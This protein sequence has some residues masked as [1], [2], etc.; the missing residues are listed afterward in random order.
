[1][2]AKLLLLPFPSPPAAPRHPPPPKSLFLGASLPLRPPALAPSLRLLRPRAPRLAVVAQAAVKRRKE[3][4]FDNVIQR[5]KK[6]KLVLKLR[7]ILVSQPD[8]V[9][10]LRDLGRFRRDLGLTRKRRLIALLKRFPGVFEIVEEG[11]YSLRFRLTPAAERLYLD[12]L[13]LKNESEGL[14]VT[15]LRKLLMMSQEKRILIEK[16]AHLKQDLGL[17]P[18]FRDTICLRYPQYFR[19]VQMDRGPGL[20]LTHW[21]PELAVSAA[22]VAEEENRA[23]EAEERNL[24]IDRPLKFNRVKL[25]HGLK[26]S[27]GESRRVARFREMPYISPYADFSHLRSGSDEKEKHACAV[28]H[29]ILSLTL[30]KRTLVDHLTH[31]REEFR[32]S[33]SLRGMIIRHPDMFYVSLKGDR[34]SVFLREA[35][36]NSQLIEKSKLV[37]L[38]EKMRALVA[39]PRFPRRGVPETIQE[40]DGINRAAQMLSEGSDTEDDDEGLSDMEDLI[41]EISGGKS[42]ADYHWGDGWVGENDDSPPDFEDD[43]DDSSLKEV[44][45]TMKTSASSAN[46]KTHAPVFPDG[47]PRERW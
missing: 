29:E 12:E 23:R 43:D 34:D 46:G 8:R 20:E 10:S 3:I 30:E 2:D 22:E 7:N 19:L 17:P 47:K 38:K 27:R 14:A 21:D 32:F 36:K 26:L 31:F 24:I 41:T 1:M 25:P 42:D 18:E 33:Q 16:I 28:V 37:L 45:V 6:L 35:Y 39:V 9:M 4:P 40:A 13:H 11:V 44:K 5:D 15:K